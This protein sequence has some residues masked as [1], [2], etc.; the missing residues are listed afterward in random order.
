MIIKTIY[1][2]NA[3]INIGDWDYQLYIDSTG[4]KVVG[5]PLPDGAIEKNEEVI[6]NEDGSRS[7]VQHHE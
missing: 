6:T 3:L 7:V 5:N 1:F 4:N 2:N